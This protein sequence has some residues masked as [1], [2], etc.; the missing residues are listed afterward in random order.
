MAL[1][2]LRINVKAGD[3]QRSRHAKGGKRAIHP[4]GEKTYDVNQSQRGRIEIFLIPSHYSMDVIIY[5]KQSLTRKH[6][7]FIHRKINK[8]TGSAFYCG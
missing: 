2:G 7:D 5:K 6:N 4:T 3:D 8:P 1:K